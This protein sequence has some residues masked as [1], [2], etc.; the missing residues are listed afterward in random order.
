MDRSCT[1][2]Q[3]YKYSTGTRAE[4]SS[5]LWKVGAG[6]AT[7]VLYMGMIQID[8]SAYVRIRLLGGGGRAVQPPGM[9]C[10]LQLAR[11]SAVFYYRRHRKHFAENEFPHPAL[12][13]V[14]ARLASWDT[15]QI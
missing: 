12:H 13:Q 11:L 1:S 5:R 3:V 4:F 10:P 9:I 6:T 2:T 8:W 14:N 15:I 7:L